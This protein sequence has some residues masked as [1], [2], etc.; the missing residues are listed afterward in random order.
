MNANFYGTFM[1]FMFFVK[2]SKKSKYSRASQCLSTRIIS[3]I[4]YFRKDLTPHCD[5][6]DRVPSLTNVGDNAFMGMEGIV[7]F[8]GL[9]GAMPLLRT[10][11]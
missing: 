5:E 4:G 8:W 3:L 2:S 11:G 6:G 10:E 7:P 9:R 1:L